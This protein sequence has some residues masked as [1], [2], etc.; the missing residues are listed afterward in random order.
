MESPV[1]YFVKIGYVARSARRAGTFLSVREK[2]IRVRYC[3]PVFGGLFSFSFF[4]FFLLIPFF[5]SSNSFFSPRARGVAPSHIG[6]FEPGRQNILYVYVQLGQRPYLISRP[7]IGTFGHFPKFSNEL[8]FPSK[9][10]TEVAPYRNIPYQNIIAFKNPSD[11]QPINH[12]HV[13]FT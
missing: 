13:L 6:V 12:S 1:L 7:L 5:L 10:C 8:L 11:D 2:K 4:F 3:D 9:R